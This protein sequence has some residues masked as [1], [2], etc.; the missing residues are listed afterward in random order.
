MG[1]LGRSSKGGR[2][3]LYL[4]LSARSCIVGRMTSLMHHFRRILSD[5]PVTPTCPT[6]TNPLPP[7]PTPPCPPVPCSTPICPPTSCND[8]KSP[9][10]VPMPA[11]KPPK[12]PYLD[13]PLYVD[14]FLTLA[15]LVAQ[16]SIDPS[17]K[18]GAVLVAADK[19]ILSTGY[20]GPLRGADDAKV[21][22]TR[23]EK[24]PHFLHAEENAIL[25]YTGSLTD[26]IGSTM[27]I[28]GRP[29]HKCLRMIIQRGIPNII[30]SKSTPT[31]MQTDESE[32]KAWEEMMSYLPEGRVNYHEI[33]NV[34]DIH[35][36]LVTTADYIVKKNPSRF[37]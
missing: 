5:F 17:S 25:A 29:C 6:V 12:P 19:R 7:M 21:P 30:V 14:Y 16:R 18:C 35:R 15:N 32:I 8:P 24:Y 20:N 37:Y 23:P 27:Y 4:D 22:L 36:L 28:T 11:V 33:N 13:K 10:Y 9:N 1:L 2:P 26:L 31:V 3:F 34:V